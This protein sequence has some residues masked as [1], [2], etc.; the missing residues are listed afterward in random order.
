MP[1]STIQ[2]QT[3]RRP[4]IYLLPEPLAVVLGTE[5]LLQRFL[6]QS[7][8][9]RVT[10]VKVARTC[11]T[12]LTVPDESAALAE[13]LILPVICQRA[14]APPVWQ[15]VS[16]V[17]ERP[18]W[19]L[20][21]WLDP[22]TGAQ[23]LS[24]INVESAL[25]ELAWTRR[26]CVGTLLYGAQDASFCGDLARAGWGI[27]PV[28]VAM[29]RAGDRGPCWGAWFPPTVTA[30]L[31]W[32][33][34]LPE[35]QLSPAPP[36][37]VEAP[38]PPAAS[39]AGASAVPQADASRAPVLGP[40]LPPP[41]P[42]GPLPPMRA[43][44]ISGLTELFDARQGM[45]DDT[46]SCDPDPADDLFLPDDADEPPEP[47]PE[48]PTSFIALL[49]AIRERAERPT[50]PAA[51][52][53]LD[54]WQQGLKRDAIVKSVCGSWRGPEA[55]ATRRALDHVLVPHV[56]AAQGDDLLE[57]VALLLLAAADPQGG[58]KPSE[59]ARRF[60][61]QLS[62]ASSVRG[63]GWHSTLLRAAAYIQE[64][65][66][67]LGMTNPL[68]EPEEP[69]ADLFPPDIPAIISPGAVHGCPR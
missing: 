28:T 44:D 34:R 6:A 8:E 55:E 61:L 15:R 32:Y 37:P 64:L 46:W 22:Y 56:L 63:G 31:P 45:S 12:Y 36:V 66:G 43:K 24:L 48:L 68:L 52:V 18:E 20:G 65:L 16:S 25:L 69:C 67:E 58:Y 39:Q 11:A 5:A 9:L 3:S 40:P 53:I 59:A 30:A 26:S 50:H 38:T 19:E 33:I 42:I 29:A 2:E 60:L 7:R 35:P 49:D 1:W 21:C 23:L 57:V 27:H 62:G 54:G 47:E 10:W 14:T 13:R 4:V 17:L 51:A 41:G